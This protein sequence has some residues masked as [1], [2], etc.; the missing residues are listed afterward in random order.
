[1]CFGAGASFASASVLTGVGIASVAKVRS[2]GERLFAVIPLIFAVQQFLEGMLWVFLNRGYDGILKTA[3]TYAF[4][5]VAY[6]FWP[7]Y[8]PLSIRALEPREAKHRAMAWFVLAGIATAAYL[9]FFLLSTPVRAT[10]VQCSIFYDPITP[11]PR[12]STIIY[13]IVIF[14]P[15][16]FCSYRPVAVLGIINL[17]FCAVA[18]YFYSAAFVSVWCFFAAAL[19]VMIYFFLRQ[20]AA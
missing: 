7:V 6:V 15:F 11:G 12:A 13:A 1:M 10:V 8:A 19:S 20:T 2:P 18:Y 16:L 14:A 17:I 3:L 9:S 4:L 5:F